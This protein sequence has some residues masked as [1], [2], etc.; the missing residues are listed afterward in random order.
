MMQYEQCGERC[1]EHPRTADAYAGFLFML[2][3]IKRIIA[4]DLP[5]LQL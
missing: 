2:G 3:A 5:H 1:K 4:H